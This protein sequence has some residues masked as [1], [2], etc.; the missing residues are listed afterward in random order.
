VSE[1]DVERTLS[2]DVHDYYARYVD[3]ADAKTGGLLTINAAGLTL[4]FAYLPGPGLALAAM[5]LSAGASAIALGCCLE[6]LWPRLT[7]HGTSLIF[8][9]DVNKKPS[10]EAYADEVEA[11]DIRAVGRAYAVNNYYVA[12]VLHR[13][14]AAI[15]RAIVF[16]AVALAVA[17]VGL[18]L[19]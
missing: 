18:I 12:G 5:L 19:R 3:N 4:N 10:A 14:F 6:A 15:Q 13:K 1:K 17:I 2:R 9:E 8:W 7:S 16:S 11:L